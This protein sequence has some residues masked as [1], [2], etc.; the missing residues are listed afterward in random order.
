VIKGP[1]LILGGRSDIG[2]AAAHRFAA[3]GHPIQLAARNVEML[4]AEKSDIE[5]RHNVPVTLHE[6]DALNAESHPAFVDRLQVL[7]DIAV[8]AVGVLGD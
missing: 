1:V 4:V 5:L 2:L 6:F 8:C 3:V 7:P